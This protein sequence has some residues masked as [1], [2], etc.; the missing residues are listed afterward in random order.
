M[1]RR[2]AGLSICVVALLIATSAGAEMEPVKV[3]FGSLQISGL[4]QAG[5]NYYIGDEIASKRDVDLNRDGQIAADGSESNIPAAVDR[6]SDME[7]IIRRAR[8]AFKGNVVD[9]HIGYFFQTDVQD[10]RV[11]LLDTRLAFSYIPYTTI[12]IGR[13][14]PKFTY[15]MPM[16]PAYTYLIDLPQMNSFLG[17]QRQTGVNVGVFHRLFEVD[18]GAFNGRNEPNISINPADRAGEPLGTN[19]Q[20]RW[21]DENTAKDA[22]ASFA[23]KPIDGLRIFGG[24][25]YGMP[26]DYFEEKDGDLT[27]HNAKVG[28]VNGGVAY[29]A[30]FGLHLWGEVMSQSVRFDSSPS[31]DPN[32]ERPNDTF[33]YSALSWY[34]MAGYDFKNFGVPFEVLARYDWLDPDTTNDEKTHGDKD[35]QT[36]ITGGFN[37]YIEDFFAVLAVNYVYKAEEYELLDKKLEEDQTGVFNDELQLQVQVHF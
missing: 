28:I 11:S 8:I 12:S 35:I 16:N 32:G 9:E 29:L 37:Y 24:Y 34:A 14:L 27:A 33:E 1:K 26:L 6:A 18:F 22:Y 2:M 25:W 15:W 4:F 13:F 3:G 10:G 19:T 30:H 5:F 20:D 7:F 23:V 17:V 36:R 21:N 31:T